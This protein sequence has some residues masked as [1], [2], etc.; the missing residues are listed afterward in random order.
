MN[1]LKIQDLSFYE[2]AGEKKIGGASSFPRSFTSYIHNFSEPTL[3]YEENSLVV[4]DNRREK[5]S[6]ELVSSQDIRKRFI[7]IIRQDLRGV[8]YAISASET[9]NLQPNNFIPQLNNLT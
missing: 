5:N 9:T 1:K 6:T 3:S 2:S 4:E 7:G 8:N